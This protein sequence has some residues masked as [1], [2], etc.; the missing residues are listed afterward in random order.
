MIACLVYA[1]VPCCQCGQ[2]VV[3]LRAWVVE[4][5]FD[6]DGRSHELEVEILECANCGELQVTETLDEET[7]EA[8]AREILDA[9]YT[10]VGVVHLG[11][12]LGY[13]PPKHDRQT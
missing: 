2:T 12:I 7:L 13:Y 11:D 9:V 4:T 1:H 8:Q 3:P 10:G 6:E 5:G